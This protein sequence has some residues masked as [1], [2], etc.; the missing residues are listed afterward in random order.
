MTGMFGITE[1]RLK[2]SLAVARRCYELTQ[3]KEYPEDYCRQMFLMGYVHDIGYEFC[4]DRSEHPKIAADILRSLTYVPTKMDIAIREHGTFPTAL[5][6]EWR[7]LNEA[8]MT[9]S[10]DGRVISAEERLA[11]IGEKYGFQSETYE[12]ARD[13]CRIVGLIK[14]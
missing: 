3:A 5:S 14:E 11:E 7:I 9:V 8:D 10:S 1:N 13:I 12:K 4:Q 6:F 2:H